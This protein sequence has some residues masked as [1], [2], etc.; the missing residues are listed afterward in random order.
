MAYIFLGF[1]PLG[2]NGDFL[3]IIFLSQ[4]IT[5]PSL[6]ENLIKRE[7]WFKYK[8]WPDMETEK[9]IE[10]SRGWRVGAEGFGVIKKVMEKY[11]H[12][13]QRCECT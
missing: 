11:F 7:L 12:N 6:H 1:F 9:V 2:K 5:P 3:Q 13:V 4:R 10:V 8:H